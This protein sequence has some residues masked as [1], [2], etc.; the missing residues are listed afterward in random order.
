MLVD[1][2]KFESIEVGSNA[3]RSEPVRKKNFIRVILL[4]VSTGICCLH[5]FPFIKNLLAVVRIAESVVNLRSCA[6]GRRDTLDAEFDFGDATVGADN[7]DNYDYDDYDGD[8]DVN[9]NANA[10]DDINVNSD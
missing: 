3:R 10:N 4:C 5:F 1:L 6:V 2:V 9:V 7:D 8:D